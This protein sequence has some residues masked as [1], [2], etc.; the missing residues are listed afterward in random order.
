MKIGFKTSQ[1]DVDWPTLLATWELGDE[2]EVFDSAWIF[3]HF[4]SLAV[5]NGP[6]H[7]ALTALSALAARTHRLQI[8]HLVISNTYR[9]PAVLAKAGATLDHISG[10]RFVLGIGAGWHEQEHA[11]YGLEMPPIGQRISELRSA[12]RVIRALWSTPDGVS[13]DAPPY[14]LTDAY[15]RPAPLTP[16][17][18]PIWLGTQGPRGLRIA[19]E[20]ADG[21]NAS[22]TLPAF[23]PKR[24][25]LLRACE[26]V[27]RDPSTI[28][29]SAQ[30]RLAD[31]NHRALLEVAMAYGEAGVDHLVFIMPA[32]DG[33]AGLQRLADEVAVPLRERFGK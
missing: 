3:D 15:C 5:P 9:H 25:I 29:V 6:S 28:E 24:D 26:A 14:R 31:G 19:A 20:L 21:W 23:A 2:L 13:V 17:G 22:G 1:T 10:G 33:P 8:G 7:E 12:V 11:M 18:P 16:N 30:A 27:G 4:L 32:A